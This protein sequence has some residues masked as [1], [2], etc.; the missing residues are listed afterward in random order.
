VGFIHLWGLPVATQAQVQLL[1]DDE[2]PMSLITPVQ[3]QLKKPAKK[4]PGKR[5]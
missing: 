5:K 4:T 1:S 3:K 2:G